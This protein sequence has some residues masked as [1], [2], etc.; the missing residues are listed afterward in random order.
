VHVELVSTAVECA[1]GLSSDGI[2]MRLE[3][4]CS[5]VISTRRRASC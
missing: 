3:F 4:T 2:I 1:V 5:L